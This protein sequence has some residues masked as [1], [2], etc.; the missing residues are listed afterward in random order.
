M[1]NASIPVD[2]MRMR[3]G[4]YPVAVAGGRVAETILWV[5]VSAEGLERV[6]LH[7]D[8]RTWGAW[9]LPRIHASGQL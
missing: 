1:P 8:R 6:R 2:G 4:S 3:E 5:G 7:V 9:V